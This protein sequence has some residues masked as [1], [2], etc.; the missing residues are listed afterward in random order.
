MSVYKKEG[1]TKIVGFPWILKYVP[2]SSLIPGVQWLPFHS[3][4]ITV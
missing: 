1:H 3:N 2:I 4:F